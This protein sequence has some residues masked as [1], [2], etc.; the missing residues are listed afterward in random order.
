M[1]HIG[2]CKLE[3][4]PTARKESWISWSHLLKNWKRHRGLHMSHTLEHSFAI[5]MPSELNWFFASKKSSLYF[6]SPWFQ[7]GQWLPLYPGSW[8]LRK[9]VH[10]RETLKYQMFNTA[11][12]WQNGDVILY[13]SKTIGIAQVHLG[14]HWCI[15]VSKALMGS[16]TVEYPGWSSVNFMSI[17]ANSSST[18]GWWAFPVQP[19][20]LQTAKEALTSYGAAE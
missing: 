7:K 17:Q 2:Y 18:V 13:Y 15:C 16:L 20:P 19:S 5:S 10:L 4:T 12:Y 14:S 11:A 3:I 8:K 9:D 1:N 6:C